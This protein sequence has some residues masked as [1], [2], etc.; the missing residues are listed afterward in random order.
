MPAIGDQPRRIGQAVGDHEVQLVAVVGAVE[1]LQQGIEVSDQHVAA[2]ATVGRAEVGGGD[3]RDI[4]IALAAGGPRLPIQRKRVVG[5]VGGI[6][7]GDEARAG[8]FADQPR[9]RGAE[10][11]RL[12][13]GF[14]ELEIAGPRRIVAGAWRIKESR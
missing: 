2:V 4:R 8:A 12:A 14:L 5:R 1:I 9:H 10:I 7:P 6:P 13:R 3:R 11:A